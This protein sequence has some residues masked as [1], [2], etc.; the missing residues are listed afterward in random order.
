[1]KEK[2]I[3]DHGDDLCMQ[4]EDVDLGAVSFVY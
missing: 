3:K 1:M 2:K 4:K